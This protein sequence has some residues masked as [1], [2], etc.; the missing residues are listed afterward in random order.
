M[1]YIN[2]TMDYNTIKYY[3]DKIEN[4]LNMCAYIPSILGGNGN[5]ANVSEVSLKMLYS[6][7]D[8]FAMCNERVMRE[9][10][11][12]RINVIRK[13]IGEENDDEYV[14]FTFNYAR[15]QNAT[16]L[17]D[18]LKKQSDMGAI[19]IQTIVEQS[20]LTTDVTMEL[21]RLKNKNSN[22]ENNK[23]INIAKNNI[24]E[25]DKI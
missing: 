9:G 17:L 23:Q 6:L 2:A 18:N 3:L 10:I 15:P 12:E 24:D 16:E 4:N 5:I 7:A 21:D 11:S 19:S 22:D 25:V 20:P 14:N 8:V 1:K 13:L